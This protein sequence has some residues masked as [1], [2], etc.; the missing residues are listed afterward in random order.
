V[1]IVRS[2]TGAT[3]VTNTATTTGRN[4]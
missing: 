4:Q 3:T 1:R 2:S